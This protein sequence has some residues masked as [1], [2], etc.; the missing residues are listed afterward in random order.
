MKRLVF[1]LL[2][3]AAACGPDWQRDL[4][5]TP[6]CP[7]GTTQSGNRCL[8]P[9]V[10]P[11]GTLLLDGKCI[12]TAASCPAGS[13]RA[14]DSREAVC[15]YDAVCPA[16]STLTGGLC[17]KPAVCPEGGCELPLVCE[18]SDQVPMDGLCEV[19]W[20]CEG[21][22]QEPDENG[23]CEIVPECPEGFVEV[24]GKPGVCYYHVE[25]KDKHKEYDYE[26]GKCRKVCKNHVEQNQ[27]TC[28]NGWFPAFDHQ[29]CDCPPDAC[30]NPENV[31]S[32]KP[33][34]VGEVVR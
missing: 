34:H 17:L 33:K 27:E 25:C 10:C 14:G 20:T 18:D 7:E 1:V 5:S 8:L 9:A 3:C 31:K 4:A 29:A 2:L 6:G 13:T 22:E 21:S 30:Q 12:L 24:E 11:V 19:E 15:Y 23:L 16:G 28:P 32:C 26:A